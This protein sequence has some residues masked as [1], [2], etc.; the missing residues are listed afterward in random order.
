MDKSVLYTVYSSRAPNERMKKKKWK[1]KKVDINTTP[2]AT[3]VR[4]KMKILQD[5]CCFDNQ[6]NDG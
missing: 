6:K 1:K 4:Q 5:V 3:N 2:V